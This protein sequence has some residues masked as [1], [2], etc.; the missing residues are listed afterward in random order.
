MTGFLTTM[1]IWG[2]TNIVDRVTDYVYVALIRYLT[3]DET[4]LAKTSF[5]RH[6]HNGGVCIKSYCADNGRFAD[7]G[8]RDAIDT[9]NQQITFCAVG[10]HHQ[11]GIVDRRIKE[12]MLI[13]RTLLLHAVRHWPGYITTMRWPFALKEA[14]YR[15][16]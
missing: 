13:G 9:S 1:R 16:N 2:A 8:F 10:A 11:N 3:L 15:L 4:L 7:Q 5:E 14:T 6:A 12:L